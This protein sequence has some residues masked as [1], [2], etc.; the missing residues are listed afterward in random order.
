MKKTLT[1]IAVLLLLTGSTY[2]FFWT[3]ACE[4]RNSD[5]CFKDLNQLKKDY[6]KEEKKAL[7][8]Q[9]KIDSIQIEIDELEALQSVH[10]VDKALY[11]TEMQKI[12]NN[13]NGKRII[14]QE[15]GF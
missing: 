5:Q 1:L 4:E 14:L 2:A 13:A 12:S 9:A 3:K 7:K 6:S 8:E 15:M 10:E 11:E